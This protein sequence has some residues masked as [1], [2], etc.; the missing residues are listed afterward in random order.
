[1]TPY[2]YFQLFTY[3]SFSLQLAGVSTEEIPFLPPALPEGYG[4]HKYTIVLDMDA[5]ASCIQSNVCLLHI[6]LLL[7]PRSALIL[8][9]LSGSVENSQTCRLGLLPELDVTALRDC[10]VHQR[11]SR[12]MSLIHSLGFA[13]SFVLPHSPLIHFSPSPFGSSINIISQ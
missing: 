7:A 4:G 3:F 6:P 12:G 9:K 8:P 2:P 1:M 11:V 5:L 10:F 13:I